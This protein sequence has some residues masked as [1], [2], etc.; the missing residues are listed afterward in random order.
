VEHKVKNLVVG[1]IGGLAV[2][3]LAGA[4]LGIRNALSAPVS[5]SPSSLEITLRDR[6][7]DSLDKPHHRD[8]IQEEID[9]KVKQLRME[10]E[11]LLRTTTFENV[12]SVKHVGE[13]FT[14]GTEFPQPSSEDKHRIIEAIRRVGARYESYWWN[15]DW[16]VSP[17]KIGDI[18]DIKH[19]A[20]WS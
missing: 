12:Q 20:Y 2:V 7:A 19:E 13:I 1:G 17:G 18:F 14:A 5:I 10:E 11:S 16:K 3:G 6:A 8:Q 4:F 9:R 15:T